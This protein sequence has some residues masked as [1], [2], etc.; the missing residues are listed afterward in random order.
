M[1][2]Y[3]K[4]RF[5]LKRRITDINEDYLKHLTGSIHFTDLDKAGQEFLAERNHLL[6]ELEIIDAERLIRKAS[7]YGVDNL[8]PQEIYESKQKGIKPRRYFS[9]QA[10][11][12]LIKMVA[13]A[14]YKWWKRWVDL[15][16]PI[17]SLLV[18]ALAFMKD[19]IIAWIVRH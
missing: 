13:D 8:P 2:R 12:Q 14:R 9:P 4:R 7:R 17:L 11:A 19:I 10:K 3:L 16:V 5:S 18:A 15:F 6:L 1:F